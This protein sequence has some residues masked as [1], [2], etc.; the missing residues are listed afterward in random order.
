MRIT[1]SL[2]ALTMIACG[3]PTAGGTTGDDPAMTA[4]GERAAPREHAIRTTT[5]VPVPQ[6]AVARED[7]SEPLQT[8]WT[9]IEETVALRPP[10]APPEATV[11]AVNEWAQGPFTVWLDERR[12]MMRRAIA[13]SEAVPD[14]PV[15][16]RAMAAAL[17]GYS[18]EDFT[19]D[20]RGAPVPE[21]IAT[22]GGMKI[23]QN[24]LEL[25]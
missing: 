10:E 7:L 11:E 1:L 13:T 24:F 12:G 20:F 21:S 17:L 4:G 18:L 3:G 22:E 9:Q 19:A 15:H 16:E 8:L 6:P 5:P 14:E 25:N 2:L 23:L